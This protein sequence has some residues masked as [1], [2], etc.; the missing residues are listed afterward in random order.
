MRIFSLKNNSIIF[1]NINEINY[2][3]F[4]FIIICIKFNSKFLK[5]FKNYKKI[6]K[7]KKY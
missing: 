5:I 6:L 7:K 4:I 3:Y 2:I 1:I